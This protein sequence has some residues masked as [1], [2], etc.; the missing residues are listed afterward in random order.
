MP[1]ARIYRIA[2]KPSPSTRT[3]RRKKGAAVVD[4]TLACDYA[5]PASQYVMAG[6]CTAAAW[7]RAAYRPALHDIVMPDMNGRQLAVRALQI[8]LKLKILYTTAYT[9][10]AIVHN[11]M[12]DVGTVVL[13]KPLTI[14]QLATKVRQVLDG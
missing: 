9:R 5:V 14:D 4:D 1:V 7:G 3:G 8:L 11:G 13:P 10:N 2:K 6:G 12:L